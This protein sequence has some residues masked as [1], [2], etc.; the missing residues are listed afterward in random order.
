M[1]LDDVVEAVSI[2]QSE[3]L[4]QATARKVLDWSEIP[5]PVAPPR[6]GYRDDQGRLKRQV[7]RFRVYGYD[8]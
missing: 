6:G 7:A 5:F 4:A 1:K 8:L 2:P 3:S